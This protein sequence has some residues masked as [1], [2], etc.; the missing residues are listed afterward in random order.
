MPEETQADQR[1]LEFRKP[2]ARMRWH[3]VHPVG[4]Y[5]LCGVRAA[6]GTC[7]PTTDSADLDRVCANCLRAW[8]EQR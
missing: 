8:G 7:R 6:F 1:S 2:N 3:L 5:A 4:E